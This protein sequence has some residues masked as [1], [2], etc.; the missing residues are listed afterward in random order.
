MSCKL[1]GVGDDIETE[2][3]KVILEDATDGN[4]LHDKLRAGEEGNQE[5]G[6]IGGFCQGCTA[7]YLLIDSR[8]L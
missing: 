3:N 8:G 1:E 4:I 2:M 7:W 5:E 6:V